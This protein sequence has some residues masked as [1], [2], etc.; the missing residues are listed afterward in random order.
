MVTCHS[1]QTDA[2]HYENVNAWCIRFMLK[3]YITFMLFWSCVCGWLSN[4]SVM[5]LW[6]LVAGEE[7]LRTHVL[8]LRV[9]DG[10]LRANYATTW[11]TRLAS[12]AD[13]GQNQVKNIPA[14]IVF[15][16]MWYL[17]SV[18]AVGFFFVFVVE[19]WTCVV[20]A[21]VSCWRHSFIPRKSRRCCSGWNTWPN[22]SG[23]VI[24][25]VR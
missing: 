25:R 6:R 10:Q 20:A 24:E 4:F 9:A 16:I 21:V 1:T 23:R 17:W 12:T 3:Y 22:N 5:L 19:D 8:R 15:F 14:F 18:V 11:R 2:L 13:G 7:Y